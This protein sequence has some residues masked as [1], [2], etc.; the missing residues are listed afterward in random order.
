MPCDGQG[1]LLLRAETT[2]VFYLYLTE[3]ML[4]LHLLVTVKQ[5]WRLSIFP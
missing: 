1:S 4:T 3:A 2:A 5:I